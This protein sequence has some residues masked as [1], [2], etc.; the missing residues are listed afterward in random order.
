M[1]EQDLR[2]E[3]IRITRIITSQG[4]AR[5]SDGN[6]SVRLAPDRFLVTPSGLYKM[7]MSPDD[8]VIVDAEGCLVA[9]K[10]GRRPT[11]ELALH[12][13]AYRQRPDIGAVLHAHPPYTTALTIV[14]LPFPTDY[15][16]EVMVLL[17][18]V[19]TAPYARPLT[20]AL[21]TSIRELIRTHDN[22]LLSHHGTISVA[23]TLQQALIAL[24][25]MEAVAYTYYL[26][27][28]LGEPVPLPQTELEGLAALG[29]QI[30]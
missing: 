12:L 5:S 2:E 28:G 3:I 1:D 14:E 18:R 22:I 4:L 13:E 20:P 19:P 17:G 9:G 16:P 29:R 25:R 11:G 21:A 23:R 26:A 30:S 6:I 24:E 27:R 8:L 10:A 15:M 7:S